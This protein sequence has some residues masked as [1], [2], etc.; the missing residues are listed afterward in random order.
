MT[1]PQWFMEEIEMTPRE[2]VA[3]IVSAVRAG[4]PYA[5]TMDH[6]NEGHAVHSPPGVAAFPNQIVVE[7]RDRE[8]TITVTENRKS[9]LK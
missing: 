7:F 5:L 9:R 8:Y 6:P 4:V 3:V 1:V 2:R